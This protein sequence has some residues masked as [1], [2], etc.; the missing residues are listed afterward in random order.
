MTD[1]KDE[2]EG[3]KMDDELEE[4]IEIMKRKVEK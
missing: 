2:D 3:D 4:E 1:D